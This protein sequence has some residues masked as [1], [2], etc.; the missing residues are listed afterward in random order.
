MMGGLI[1]RPEAEAEL[2]EAF[3]GLRKNRSSGQRYATSD[4]KGYPKFR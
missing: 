1:I 3:E 2:A 4:P